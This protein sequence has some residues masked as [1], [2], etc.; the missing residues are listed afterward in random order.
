M[1][2][3]NYFIIILRFKIKINNKI[4][5]FYL[6]NIFKVLTIFHISKFL[7]DL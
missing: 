7:L 1:I 6:E 4:Y 3:N 5:L 2:L